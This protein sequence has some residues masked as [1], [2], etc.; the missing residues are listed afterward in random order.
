M[1]KGDQQTTQS[2]ISYSRWET[3]FGVGV[4][5]GPHESVYHGLRQT[6]SDL[7]TAVPMPL[8]ALEISQI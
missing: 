2:R 7:G 5:K 1:R 6:L 4:V 8:S 3:V